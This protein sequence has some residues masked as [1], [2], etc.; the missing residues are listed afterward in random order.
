MVRTQLYLSAESAAGLYPVEAVEGNG[1]I[2]TAAEQ[3]SCAQDCW[4]KLQTLVQ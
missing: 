3:N 4:D 2:A 1:R